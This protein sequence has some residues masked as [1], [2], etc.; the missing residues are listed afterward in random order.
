MTLDSIDLTLW[1]AGIG[2]EA[3]LLA[4]AVWKRIYRTLPY[5]FY[6][7]IWCLCSEGMLAIARPVPSAYL[8]VT[9]LGITVD[10]LFQLAILAELARSVVRYNRIFRPNGTVLA[11]LTVLGCALAWSLNRW[12]IPTNTPFLE[13]LYVVLLEIIAVLRLAFLLALVWWSSLQK[14]HWPAREL[15]ILTGCHVCLLRRNPPLPQHDRNAVPLAG[16]NARGKLFMDALLL[17]A[18]VY[19]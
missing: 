11:I 3:V 13:S 16:S 1:L 5:F 15:Q 19:N 9:L 12:K 14:L 8:P 6:Y 17:D 4:L 2:M 10:A 7:L 18:R